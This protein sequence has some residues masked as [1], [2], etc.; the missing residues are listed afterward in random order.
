MP[1][2]S[3]ARQIDDNVHQTA[4]LLEK[5]DRR[6]GAL[7]AAA[8]VGLVAQWK[9]LRCS[10]SDRTACIGK[11]VRHMNRSATVILMRGFAGDRRDA[12][13]T[14]ARFDTARLHLMAVILARTGTMPYRYS[15][16]S[17]SGSYN[18]RPSFSGGVEGRAGNGVR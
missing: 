14:L 11:K 16:S 1:A 12:V 3:P 6:R 10:T 5:T 13:E 7:S 9:I 15:G 4:G 18:K 17:T 8:R 2:S